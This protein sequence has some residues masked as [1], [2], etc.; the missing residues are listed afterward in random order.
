MI[1]DFTWQPNRREFE[2]RL[3]EDSKTRCGCLVLHKFAEVNIYG[4]TKEEVYKDEWKLVNFAKTKTYR[5]TYA[6]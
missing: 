4:E 2:T 6:Q 5:R 3:V 1:C